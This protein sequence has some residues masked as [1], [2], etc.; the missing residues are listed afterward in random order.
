M[1]EWG[2]RDGQTDGTK[3]IVECQ[4]HP[5][6]VIYVVILFGLP[7]CRCVVDVLHSPPYGLK[8]WLGH[9]GLCAREMTFTGDPSS[10]ACDS[11]I[12]LLHG[13]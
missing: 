4:T 11:I 13:R 5:V 9:C 7:V 12:S 6:S 2:Q 3:C 1:D 8:A 10:L